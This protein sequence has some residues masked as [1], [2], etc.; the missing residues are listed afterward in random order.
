MTALLKLEITVCIASSFRA[1]EEDLLFETVQSG[2]PYFFLNVF[3]A[4]KGACI[5]YL[6]QEIPAV[7]KKDKTMQ[8][9]VYDYYLE[10]SDIELCVYVPLLYVS[11]LNPRRGRQTGIPVYQVL[12][13]VS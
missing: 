12:K 9:Q 8:M 6:G 10:Y 4:L 13:G 11:Y 5:F 1:T 3:T 2:P 7:N